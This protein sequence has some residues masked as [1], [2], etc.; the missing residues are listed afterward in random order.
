MQ[1]SGSRQG[2][3]AT[4]GSHPFGAIV[5]FPNPDGEM[6]N[7]KRDAKIAEYMRMMG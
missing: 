3:S 4:T 5:H 7:P 1:I 6:E 2:V